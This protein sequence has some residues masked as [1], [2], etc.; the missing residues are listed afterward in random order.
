MIYLKFIPHLLA[1]V[2]LTSSVILY[3]NNQSLKNK[4]K[5]YIAQLEQQHQENN[6]KLLEQVRAKEH[7]L[8]VKYTEA[9]EHKRER[10]EAIK[11]L[12]TTISANSSR[13][14]QLAKEAARSCRDTQTN[15]TKVVEKVI[16]VP[17]D[18]G[19]GGNTTEMVA[20][21]ARDFEGL[22]TKCATHY[23]ELKNEAKLLE[24]IQ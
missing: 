10:D 21:M 8:T 4:H 7:E 9:L 6:L 12:N 20:D 11:Q 15:T 24:D 16:R 13:L 2:F 17:T 3:S 22:A 19:G 23:E 18:E 1:L 5:A 14:Q